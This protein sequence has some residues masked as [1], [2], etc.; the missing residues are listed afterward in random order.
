MPC[1]R[2]SGLENC[3][4]LGHRFDFSCLQGTGELKVKYSFP[5]CPDRALVEYC[6]AQGPHD[7]SLYP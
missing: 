2:A 6:A 1:Q 5:V 7:L 4:D 3:L